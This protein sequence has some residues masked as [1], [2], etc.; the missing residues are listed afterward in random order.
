MYA[1][2]QLSFVTYY[3]IVILWYVKNL[4]KFT[5][6]ALC[7]WSC[8]VSCCCKRDSYILIGPAEHTA[9]VVCREEERSI[10]GAYAGVA[11]SEHLPDVRTVI[12]LAHE[13]LTEAL[14]T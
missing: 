9:P 3:Y 11:A 10:F 4:E 7:G 5:A 1:I 8:H 13:F 14:V 6:H 12:R 2:R